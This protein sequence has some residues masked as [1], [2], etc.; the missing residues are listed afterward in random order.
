MFALKK[1]KSLP[2]ILS[3]NIKE[4]IISAFGFSSSKEKDKFSGVSYGFSPS[5]LPHLKEGVTG[6]IQCKVIDFVD[7]YTHT[8]FI[9]EVQEAEN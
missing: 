3:E 2:S 8:I 4:N 1:Q 9:A 5:G 7:N 6:Y